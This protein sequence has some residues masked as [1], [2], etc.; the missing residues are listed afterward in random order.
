[1]YLA[2][3]ICEVIIRVFQCE[4]KC[5]F[6]KQ[7]AL[8]HLVA[9]LNFLIVLG[10]TQLHSD[11]SLH[12]NASFLI[13]FICVWPRSNDCASLAIDSGQYKSFLICHLGSVVY[14]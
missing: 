3:L 5:Q 12:T 11:T 1:M 9:G 10:E 4:Y 6:Q 7:F 13:D 14:H 2:L 8:E